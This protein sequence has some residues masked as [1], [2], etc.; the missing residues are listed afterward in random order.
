MNKLLD[1]ALEE[2]LNELFSSKEFGET[3]KKIEDTET[4]KFKVVVTTEGV[5]RDGETLKASGIDF[6]A[7]MNN[8][9]V[10]VDH[11]YTIDSI[12]GKTLNIYQENGKTIAEGVFAN[13]ENAKIV[14]E[15]YNGGFV[16]TVS[17]GFIPKSRNEQDKDIIEKAEMLEFS[18]VAVPANPEALSLDG[19]TY[20][21]AVENGLIKEVK[22]NQEDEGVEEKKVEQEIDTKEVSAIIK[23][24][25]EEIKSEMSEIKELL[26]T[27]TDDKVE[28]KQ[29]KEARENAQKLVKGLSAYLRDTK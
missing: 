29:L 4:N 11:R 24:F 20:K 1:K 23:E 22:E 27:L 17:I 21:K 3:I 5:D 2:K 19:K 28:A 15:L 14:K 25:K 12:V 26:K 18:F 9:V 13:T 16:K 10:L 8:P 7:Y 6:E